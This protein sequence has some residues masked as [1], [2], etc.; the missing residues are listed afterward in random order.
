MKAQP[1]SHFRL[2]SEHFPEQLSEFLPESQG[3]CDVTLVS[4]DHQGIR[5]HQAVL[6]S[7]SGVIRHLLL[8]SSDPSPVIYL[9]GT[10]EQ[11]VRML[12]EFMYSGKVNPSDL[13]TFLELAKHYEFKQDVLSSLKKA[14]L[15]EKHKSTKG[16][17]SSKQ[18]IKKN[19]LLGTTEMK[20]VAKKMVNLTKKQFL[21]CENDLPQS[22]EFPD[23]TDEFRVQSET[24]QSQ[25]L[26]KNQ[27]FIDSYGLIMPSAMDNQTFQS[28][29]SDVY[30]E[31]S[32]EL[33]SEESDGP[34]QSMNIVPITENIQPGI[35]R[36]LPKPTLFLEYDSQGRAVNIKKVDGRVQMSSEQG[37]TSF[38]SVS[39][40]NNDGA[41]ALTNVDTE[42]MTV[43]PNLKKEPRN[44]MLK[45]LRSYLDNLP[46]EPETETKLHSHV[47]ESKEPSKKQPNQKSKKRLNKGENKGKKEPLT[48]SDAENENQNH[49][50][51]KSP[52]VDKTPVR[53]ETHKNVT[54]AKD[55]KLIT[56]G[57]GTKNN[58]SQFKDPN[59]NSLNKPSSSPQP[60][61]RTE[62]M[63]VRCCECD[64]KVGH[65]VMLKAHIESRHYKLYREIYVLRQ[66]TFDDWFRRKN[67]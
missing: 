31:F 28:Q 49:Q 23:K 19:V 2:T 30:D 8:S 38:L 53:D 34:V 10:S 47:G 11:D 54:Q 42:M 67:K 36:I 58:L 12:I 62:D 18:K 27:D 61:S 40:T 63:S 13:D 17:N 52:C 46:V 51:N 25:K 37:P 65:A 35:Q 59:E 24:G 39:L 55:V 14:S 4:D 43:E 56:V 22:T 45:T 64:L 1:N 15:G 3:L 57:P 21:I 5:A 33:L 66:L 41:A 7:V 48:K 60:K 6:S 16:R 32:S 50:Q 9:Q 29:Q 44:K 20:V 26:G